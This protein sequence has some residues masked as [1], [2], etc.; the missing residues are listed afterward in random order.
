MK[1]WCFYEEENAALELGLVRTNQPFHTLFFIML[2]LFLYK[3]IIIH[4]V[5]ATV[6]VGW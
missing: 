4:S 3:L 1:G 5:F 2:S 6:T